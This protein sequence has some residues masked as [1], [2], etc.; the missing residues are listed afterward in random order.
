M[1][2]KINLDTK[3][4]NNLDLVPAQTL[5]ES[6]LKDRAIAAHEQQLQLAID[7]EREAEDPREL[8]EIPEIRLWY[9]RL[10]AVYPWLPFLLDWQA[11]ELARYAAML[12]PHQFSRGE[13]IIYN[14]EALEIFVMHKIFVL[15]TWLP[16]QGIAPRS[17]LKSMAQ[18]F[19]YEIDD[20]FFES[21]LTN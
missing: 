19:G 3:V 16:Q 11:G 12:V 21:I 14:P 15:S 5:I 17:R 7:Y 18:M 9:V 10:D 13:G 1:T 20:A 8:S 4:V 2:L 6:L